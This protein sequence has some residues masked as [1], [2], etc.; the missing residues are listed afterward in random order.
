MASQSFR[1]RAWRL[2]RF[3]NGLPVLEDFEMYETTTPP[4][5][6]G[7]VLLK[8]NHI[9][10]DPYMRTRM[11]PGP[12]YLMPGFEINAKPINGF[13]VST[14]EQSGEGT[15]LAVGDHVHGFLPWQ[16]YNVADATVGRYERVP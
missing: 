4:L 3:P 16:E 9:S 10:V 15:E 1:N 6:T 5:Q 7:Q 8:T 12:G 13:V 14:V 2:K 11:K